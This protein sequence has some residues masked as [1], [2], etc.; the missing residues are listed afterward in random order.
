MIEDLI[1]DVHNL[2]TK[3]VKLNKKNKFPMNNLQLF[4]LFL[5]YRDL[6]LYEFDSE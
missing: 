3:S 5:C 4:L 2:K 6:I 1:R